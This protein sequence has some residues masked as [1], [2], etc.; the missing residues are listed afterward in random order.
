MFNNTAHYSGKVRELYDEGDTLVIETTNRMSGF[1]R[2]LCDV[3]LKG[4]VLTQLSAWWFEKTKSIVPNHFIEL[5]SKNKMRVKK[6]RVFP[7]EV[8]V[9]GYLTG[10]TN[11]SAWSLYEAGERVFFDTVLPDGLQKNT[12]LLNPII[13]PTSKSSV[14]DEPLMTQ[15]ID[16][17]ISKDL[18][19]KIKNIAL[20]LFSFG[21]QIAQKKG[22]ILVDT[23]YEFGLDENN[24][25]CLIDEC[26]TPDSSRFW[27]D[28]TTEHYDKEYLRLWYKKNCDPYHDKILP[29]IP[30]KIIQEMSTRYIYLFEKI[31]G[32]KLKVT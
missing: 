18:W 20:D 19:E 3:P 30:E 7:I 22:L 13:T 24:N 17:Y 10:S 12:K 26:H 6:C 31:T 5:I 1:D 29:T 28:N 25:I 11:T 16:Q 21:Q 27:K 14:H 2:Y 4:D 8:V 32:E 15:N 9:R 23:K